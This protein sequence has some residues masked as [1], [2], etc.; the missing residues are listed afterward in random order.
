MFECQ[1][2]IEAICLLKYI[3]I[4]DDPSFHFK[5]SVIDHVHRTLI[6]KI[7]GKVGTRGLSWL[8][9][10]QILIECSYQLRTKIRSVLLL[11]LI[12]VDYLL[13]PQQL[14][15]GKPILLMKIDLHKFSH[16]ILKILRLILHVQSS[17]INSLNILK[18]FVSDQLV[19]HRQ[20]N[21]CAR[22]RLKYT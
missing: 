5:S 16:P 8:Q 15:Q 1:S 9:K 11:L 12:L 2:F 18:P 20:R 21:P 13:K 17:P 4:E 3:L 14:S 6:S 7:F 19:P 10:A 22:I